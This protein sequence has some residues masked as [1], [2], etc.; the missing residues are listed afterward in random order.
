VPGWP[1]ARSPYTLLDDAQRAREVLVL[2]Y[3]ASLEFFERFALADA[4]ALGAL[5]TVVSDALMVHA[6][7]VVVRRAGVQYLDARAVCPGG[8][9][10]PKLLVVVGDSQAR[11]S[12]GSG[13]L[14]TAGWHGNA[15]TWTVLSADG[16]GG[17]DTLRDVVAF[18][19]ELADSPIALGAHARPALRRVA[20]ELD[21]IPADEP[22][23]R[24]LHSLS[25]PI[26]DQIHPPDSPVT[27][28]ALYAPFH[29]AQ[30][31]GVRDLLGRLAPAAWTVFVQ[32]DTVVDGPAL[33][34][35]ADERGGRVVWV[36]RRTPSDNGGGARDER[37]W[38]GKLAQWRTAG[39]ETWA[40]T[41]SPNLSRPAL[42]ASVRE[43][44]NCELAVLSRI[45]YDLAPAI[46]DPPPGGVTS[47]SAPVYDR[48]SMGGPVLLAATA[49]AGTVSVE[50]HR[51]LDANGV[52]ERYDAVEDRWTA[53]AP[54]TGGAAR[55]ELD[56]AAAPIGHA[57]RVRTETDAVSNEVFVSDPRRIARRQQHA[58]G[59][60]RAA[61]ED[62][63]RDMLGNQLLADL[64][65]LRPHLLSVGAIVRVP[66]PGDDDPPGAGGGDESPLPA[67]PASGQTLEEYIEHCDPVLGRRM[68]EFALVLPALPGI[69]DALDDE[70]GTL[71]SDTDEDATDDG[72]E[73]PTRTVATELRSKSRGERERFRWFV[74]R[75]I[76]RSPRYPMVVRTLAARMLLHAIAARLWRE[77][78]WPALLADALRALAA[79][80]DEPRPQELQTAGSVAAV[81]LA[82][83][84]TDVPRV[85][86]RDER[87]QRYESVAHAVSGL[88]AHRDAHQVQTLAAELPGRLA[89]AA[90]VLA[91]ERAV[92]EALHPPR[93]VTRAVRLLAAERDIAAHER[94]EATVVIDEPIVGLP[95]P[96]LM[97]ALRL[98][99]DAG[100]IFARGVTVENQPVLAAW[101]APWFAAERIGKAGPWGRAWKL[102][103]H[104]TLG[105]IDR[106]DLPR[107]DVRWSAGGERPPEIRDLLALAED[108]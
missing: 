43:G 32:P 58:V 24:L 68:T 52:F 49:V 30:L 25:G 45:D 103:P 107:A 10:H 64:D 40:L 98:A 62:V 91:A 101:C 36:A 53:T 34:A 66:R 73:P 72:D 26:A 56:I 29:D 77:D 94:G 14:T 99:E 85:S 55:Y 16:D 42:L 74:E 67:R 4:R 19:R 108:D 44:G 95:E 80:G 79:G 9:F 60:V 27:D 41:G 12:I 70:H 65:Q 11:V 104:Q 23:P 15:E 106:A 13:N 17:P 48:R 22:G 21:E 54:V 33:Q 59:K 100:P 93:G 71:D 82:L 37:Y 6:D 50:L 92:E 75:L 47:L 63:V 83:L 31:A 84:R 39:G 18:L 102:G 105:V 51:A 87:Q 46:G 88:L 97:L 5:V 1:E 28:L 76:E 86:R 57:L 35:L 61:P 78:Q 96:T 20:D 2:T 90:G 81:G 89:G 38:H 3:T 69:G 7:P 8:A